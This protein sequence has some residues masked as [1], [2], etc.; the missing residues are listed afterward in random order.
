MTHLNE[1]KTQTGRLATITSASKQ[2][3]DQTIHKRASI[4]PPIHITELIHPRKQQPNENWLH[5][6]RWKPNRNTR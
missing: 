6:R 1:G 3:S 2:T 5:R 4:Q